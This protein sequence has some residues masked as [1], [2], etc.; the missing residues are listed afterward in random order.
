M[1]S[2]VPFTPGAR[3]DTRLEPFDLATATILLTGGS[4][5][6]GIALVKQFAAHG[7]K[8]II[9]GRREEEL[10]KAQAQFPDTVVKYY[11]SDAAKEVDR[12]NL[13]K[14]VIADFPELNVLINNAGIQNRGTVVDT[15]NTP[16]SA[17]ESEILIN[18]SAPIH[19]GSLFL[20]HLNQQ[21]RPA[22][23][24]NVTSGLAFV[25]FYGAPVYAATK[26]ALHS[27]TESLRIALSE[28]NVRVVNLIPPAVKSNLG[29][30]HDFG[31]DAD[32][33]ASLMV[34]KFRDGY[35]EFGMTFSD[36]SRLATRAEN[37]QSMLY[38]ANLT[39]EHGM[40]AS[41]LQKPTKASS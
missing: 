40:S 22:A 27:Y 25:P 38:L 6:I 29:G 33:F 21:P 20:D 8:V 26:A 9:T 32:E 7:S 31:E 16:W 30:S 28:S 12:V 3:F 19:Y 13:A 10:K 23:I 35:L 2:P 15:K 11:V 24:V 14:Q 18:F 37:V 36:K 39:R 41:L 4:S 5:G 1:S 34:S 17:I